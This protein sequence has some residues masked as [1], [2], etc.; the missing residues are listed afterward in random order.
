MTQSPTSSSRVKILISNAKKTRKDGDER[1]SV[2]IAQSLIVDKRWYLG[3]L[4]YTR[5]IIVNVSFLTRERES[6]KR[7]YD[8]IDRLLSFGEN[9]KNSY[10][11][12]LGEL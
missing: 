12:N 7:N 5:H 10:D 6:G 2:S 11:L 9:R 1:Y 8:K 4:T 3:T